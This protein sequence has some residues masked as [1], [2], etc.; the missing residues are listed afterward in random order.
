MLVFDTPVIDLSVTMLD[1]I[2]NDVS[3]L[4][5]R[6]AGLDVD[7]RH[8]IGSAMMRKLE[9]GPLPEWFGPVVSLAKLLGITP[10]DCFMAIAVKA[11]QEEQ[12]KRR[13]K[14]R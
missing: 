12:A 14:V 11:D 7:A 6:T 10:M 3:A 4:A 5:Y 13:E 1:R 8:A 2:L 9:V